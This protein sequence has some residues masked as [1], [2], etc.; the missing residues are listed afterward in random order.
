MSQM[1]LPSA[2]R[3]TADGL[4][5]ARALKLVAA[6]L[7]VELVTILHL[8]MAARIAR[9]TRRKS[10]ICDLVQVQIVCVRGIGCFVSL[11][12]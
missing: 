2:V 9:A 8:R 11:V 3:L 4:S 12:F 7:R 6:G 5:S 10:A 1:A